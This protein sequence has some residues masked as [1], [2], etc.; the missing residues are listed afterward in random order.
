MWPVIADLGVFKLTSWGVGLAVSFVLG[1]FILWR[2]LRED[3]DGELLLSL[4]LWL[5]VVAWVRSEFPRSVVGPSKL[6]ATE[7]KA[8]LT[9]V[10]P[11]TAKEVEVAPV[12]V[13]PPLK[14]MAVVVAFAGNG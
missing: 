8:P 14:A 5:V 7:L 3:Y 4:W 13:S 12:A 9:V 1:S 2:R 6:A 10:E 11:V